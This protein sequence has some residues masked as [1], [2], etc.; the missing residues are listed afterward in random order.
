MMAAVLTAELFLGS[1]GWVDITTD[2]RQPV[3]DSGGGITI[4][5]TDGQQ[6]EPGKAAVVIDNGTGAYSDRNPRGPY[7]GT[8]GRNTPFRCGLQLARDTFDRSLTNGY[9]TT[10]TGQAWAEYFTPTSAYAVSAGL[11]TQSHAA[12]NSI[13]GGRLGMTV[14]DSEQ[15]SDVQVPAAVTGAAVVTGH[16]HRVQVDNSNYWLRLEFNPGGTTTLKISRDPDLVTLAELVGVPGL[17]YTA[18]QPIRLRTSVVGR[19]LSVSA[20]DPDGPE[21]A[22]WMLTYVDNSAD[23]VLEPGKPGLQTWVVAGNTNTKPLLVGFRDYQIIDR[24]AVMEVPSWPPR[25]NVPGSDRWVP[26]EAAGILR[27]LSQGAKPLQS[28]LY[29]ETLAASPT[30]YW[31]LEDPDGALAAGSPIPGVAPMEPFGFSRFTEP[32]TGVPVPAAGLPVFASGTGIPG[33][34]PVLDLSQGGTLRGVVPPVTP[35]GDGVDTGWRIEWVMIA[36]RD[37]AEARIPIW[38]ETND[39]FLDHPAGSTEPLMRWEFQIESSGFFATYGRGGTAY[40]SASAS[41]S[42]FDGLPH[43]Y[44]VQADTHLESV[45]ARVYIDGL[46]VDTFDSLA[47]TLA[48]AAGQIRT[49]AINPLEE[50]N[51]TESMPI[52]GHVGV[53][54]PIPGTDPDTVAAAFGWQGETAAAR[55][56]RLCAEHGVPVAIVG[57]PADSAPMGPQPRAELVPLLAD[58]ATADRGILG[59]ARERLALTYRTGPSLC[60]QEPTITLDYPDGLIAPPLEP[61]P[62]DQD[63][64]NDITATRPGGG[65]YRAVQETGRLSVLPPSE[66]GVGTY[67]PGPVEANVATDDQVASVAEWARH[68]GTWD[69]ARYPRV[70]VQLAAP[71]WTEELTA[72]A[73]AVDSGDVVALDELPDWLPPGPVPLMARASTE[74]L[75]ETVRE[76][77]WSMVPAGPYDVATVEGDQRV[78]ADGS[79][80]AEDLSDAGMVFELA[81]TTTNGP[82]VVGDGTSM[83]DDFPMLLTI[84]G[85]GGEVVE[86]DQIDAVAGGSQTV[87]LSGRGLGGVQR[88]WPAGTPVDVT[89]PAIVAL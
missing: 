44:R 10:D 82:W 68:L 74:F 77:T 13:L 9:G 26:I 3:A 76:I 64:A 16:L 86:A 63:L 62:D 11:A 24:R 57:D 15:V 23:A 79:T 33:S 84:G 51:G 4:T 35:T 61:E 19:R 2:V 29:R 41:F 73:V 39:A 40:G 21:P 69:E 31:P 5:R 58:C 50:I 47:D 55:V 70:R 81:S 34:A 67:D 7:F 48:G 32:G 28:P 12:A 43:H 14:R 42:M 89:H 66:G 37:K 60:N 27:R 83:P 54:S 17:T 46:L 1:L 85:P 71:D 25:W 18:G 8:L 52:L 22:D 88:A 80:L 38:W 6:A 30:A 49:V 87:W 20:W 72:Q 75:D 53:W 45:R 59:E 36:P 65:S 78:A 56:E